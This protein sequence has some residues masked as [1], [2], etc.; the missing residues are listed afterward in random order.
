MIQLD[1][2]KRIILFATGVLL[3]Y[4]ATHAQNKQWSL[5]DCIEYALEN[6]IQLQKT[7]LN[8]QQAQ[9]DVLQAQAA[10]LPS[11]SASTNQNVAYRPWV[12]QGMSTVANGYVQS[13]VDKVYYNGNYGVNANW[14]VWNGNQN[15]NTLKLN[16][17]TAQ[18]AELD[19]AET[20]NSIQEQIARL[21]VQILYSY[22]A[23]EV[24]KQ[25]LETSK[26]NEERGAEMVKVGKMSK[27]DLAQ[28]TAQ[29]A[30]DEY[31]IVA[32]ESSL[33][34]YKRQL[35]QVLQ[36][37][38]GQD[39]D[40]QTPNSTDEQALSNIP[41]IAE[42]YTMAAESRPEIRNSKMAIESSELS[43]KIAKA[44]KLPTIGLNA[45][46]GTNTTSMSSN[47][48][49]R[50]LKTNFDIGA[51]VT[52]SIPLFDN[53]KTKTAM[54]KAQLQ[55]QSALLD[56][57]DKQTQLYSTIESYWLEAVNNQEKYKAAKVAVEGEKA[58]YDLLS[59]QFRLGL[60]NIVELMNGKDKLLAARQNELQSKY[61]TILYQQMLRFYQGNTMENL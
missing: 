15:R 23:V 55:R 29:R 5:K 16:S 51:G 13:S 56:L 37:T 20:A 36:I 26:K 27:A 2:M 50:Q 11:L 10:L 41:T 60:K 12:A 8:H 47:A 21:Y 24:N 30:Q 9:E 42:V 31:N 52:V 18:Q 14:T 19:S 3:F 28:L 7:L 43:M 40:I 22:E 61:T 46:A 39:F 1:N 4:S 53:R 17:L 59:E 34:D 45:S 49:G 44:G 54:N 57:K 58:S 25:S 35:R 6:N 33:K 38:D 48:W 32:A